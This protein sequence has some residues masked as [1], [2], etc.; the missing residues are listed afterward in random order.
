MNGPGKTLELGNVFNFRDLGGLPTDTGGHIHHGLLYRSDGLHQADDADLERLAE[1]GL[2]TIVDLR[3][4]EERDTRGSARAMELGA[5]LW[6]LPLIDELWPSEGVDD[7][8]D[9]GRY[10]ADRYREMADVGHRVAPPLI[11]LIADGDE[12]P[13]VFHCAAGKDRTGFTAAVLLR[14]AGV[15]IDDVAAD[16]ARTAHAMEA[17]DAWWRAQA[18]ARGHA[19]EEIPGAFVA[20]PPEAMVTFLHELEESHRSMAGYLHSLGVTADEIN[21]YRDRV[22]STST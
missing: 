3:T 9:H 19:M 2:R 17:M 13:L 16:Y 8:T 22:V 18:Q 11:R 15:S 7:S 21:A 5:R 6:H 10:L 14:T 20:S 1:L 12:L 4:A